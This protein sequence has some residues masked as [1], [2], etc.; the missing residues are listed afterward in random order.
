MNE[1]KEKKTE[2]ERSD[3][4]MLMASAITT[5]K[6]LK[7]CDTFGYTDIVCLSA[8]AYILAYTSTYVIISIYFSI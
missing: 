2:K 7:S 1:Q 5:M 3:A 8:Y 4:E 6:W